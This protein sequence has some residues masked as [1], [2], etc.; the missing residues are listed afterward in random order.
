MLSL[1]KPSSYFLL[2][3]FFDLLNPMSR[4]QLTHSRN[5]E[6]ALWEVVS[7][8]EPGMSKVSPKIAPI[9][10]TKRQACQRQPPALAWQSF[11]SLNKVLG[12]DFV[13]WETYT[14]HQRPVL[15]TIILFKCWVGSSLQ[16][17]EPS[18]FADDSTLRRAWWQLKNGGRL[19]TTEARRQIWLSGAP[20]TRGEDL[21]DT[22]FFLSSHFLA[23][24]DEY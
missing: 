23:K 7:R 20:F 15:W 4:M 21:R 16:L 22:Y 10:D 17:S 14:R 12:K 2:L 5:A 19:Q 9:G 13:P 11:C 3:C 6:W 18:S 8:V 24:W 1:A